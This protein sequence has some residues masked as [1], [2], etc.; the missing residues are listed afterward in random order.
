MSRI[1]STVTSFLFRIRP[2]TLG[3]LHLI[4]E[5]GPGKLFARQG[6]AQGDFVIGHINHFPVSGPGGILNADFLSDFEWIAFEQRDI[7][8][9]KPLPFYFL[10]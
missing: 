9:H 6:A 8:Q 3:F 7:F 2:R 4:T 5:P 1:T 10:F